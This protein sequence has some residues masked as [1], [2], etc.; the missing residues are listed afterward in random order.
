MDFAKNRAIQYQD[1]I[2]SVYY[3]QEQVTMHPVVTYYKNNN[4]LVRD[5]S[6]VISDDINHD[7][8]AVEHYK[9]IVDGHIE[10]RIGKTPERRV[11]FSDGCSAQYKSKGPFADLSLT[12]TTTDRNYFGSEHGKGDCDAE[13]GHVNKLLDRAIIGNQVIINNA[14][15]MYNYC[16]DHLTVD[17]LTSKRQFFLVSK[18]AINRERPQTAVKTLPRSRKLHQVQNTEERYVLRTRNL[19]CFCVNCKVGNSE[20]CLN[21]EYVDKYVT[22]N[23]VQERTGDKDLPGKSAKRT[24]AEVTG[25][26]DSITRPAKRTCVGVTG[27]AKPTHAEEVT[28]DADLPLRAPAKRT[29]V[30]VTRSTKRTHAEEVTGDAD[31][32][33]RAPAKRTRVR[34]TRSTKRTHAEEVTGDA[35]SPLRAPAKRTRVGVTGPAKR[36]EYF[37]KTLTDLHRSHDFDDYAQSVW[38]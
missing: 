2:K 4:I 38:T 10:G 1:E 30:R 21:Q 28:G 14:V 11:V 26:E 23:L 36:K 8:H 6:I 13:I 37:A 5:S 7:Y 16:A 3:T 29:R 18:D 33:L 24:H 35:D 31:S 12:S 15:D 32:P 20:E 9:N 22:Q 34:V 19:S 17:E 25:V 27:P